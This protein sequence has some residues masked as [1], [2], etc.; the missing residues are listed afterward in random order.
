M[1]IIEKVFRYE[2]TDLPIIKY[3]HEIWFGGKTVVEI[4]GYAIQRKAIR[5]HVDP[6]DKV[7]LTELRGGRTSK[8]KQN[9]TDPLKSKG[10]KTDPLKRNEGNTIYT[11]GSGLY[12]LVLRSKLESARAFK[13]WVTKDILPSIRKTGRYIYDDTIH[14]YND[15]LTIKIDNEIELH[16]KVV[17]FIKR[18]FPNS[19]FTATLGENQDTINKRIKSHKKGYL[20]GSPDLIINN[21][22]K[23]YTG[24]AIE[25]KNPNG[26]GILSYDQSKM[27]QKYQNNGFKTLVSNDYD[28][29]I[30]Q[31]IED[32]R[33]VRIK[34]SYC[35]R[36]FISSLSI[37]SHI[38]SFYKTA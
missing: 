37:K 17:S 11:N 9:E 19:I 24:L 15:R 25:F 38:K 7:R 22:H 32:F 28:Y 26:K 18:R 23:H 1:C 31:F 5:E 12:S 27:L 21:I 33:D 13:R 8:S 2:E 6:E 36:K 16:T 29:I 30:E 20:R 3:K 34:C 4:L 14:K 10:S 35:A